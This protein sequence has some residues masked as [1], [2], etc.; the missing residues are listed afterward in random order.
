MRE[1]IRMVVTK[2]TGRHSNIDGYE[3]GGKTGTA[4]RAESGGYNEKS[5]IA[6]F[7]AVFPSSKPQYLV[8]VVFDRSNYIFNT[9]GMVSAPVAG[10]IIKN[11]APILGVKPILEN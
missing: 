4:N 1:M 5:T 8:L 7:V 11:I 9:G 10:N 6:S 3:V 2:G